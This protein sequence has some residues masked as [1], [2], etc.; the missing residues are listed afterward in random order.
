MSRV[1]RPRSRIRRPVAKGSSVPAC[2]IRFSR[3]ARR[4]TATTSCEE[5]PAG[6]S[7]SS[8]PSAAVVGSFGRAALLVVLVL[9]VSGIG[10]G[11]RLETGEQ[12]LDARGARDAVVLPE[13]DVRCDPG[14]QRASHAPAQARRNTFESLHGGRPIFV[15]AVD[16]DEDVRL[17]EVA[18]HFDGGDG[19]E[20]DDARILDA[21]R[22]ERRDL[23]TDGLTDAVGTAG[24]TR[25]LSR[26]GRREGAGDGLLA[27]ALEN[28]ADLDVVEV[29]DADAALEP[30]LHFLHVVL[31]AA[32]GSDHA[33]VRLDA[34]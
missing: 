10:R 6:L 2:P 15:A 30:V 22:E 7:T 33:V 1:A 18:R 26:R 14:A 29:L 8:R 19:H 3:R 11:R 16:A 13:G 21:S 24:V 25:H 20:T 17:R 34:A 9:L 23:L 31:E 32:Q 4:A 27:V 12:R 5:T 28:V